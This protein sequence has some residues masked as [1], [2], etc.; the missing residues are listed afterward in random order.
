MKFLYLYLSLLFLVVSS[1]K[2][3]KITV[4][5]P[6][7][8]AVNVVFTDTSKVALYPNFEKYLIEKGIDPEKEPN[9]FVLY[10]FIKEIDSLRFEGPIGSSTSLKGIEGFTN[11]R[12]FKSEGLTVD[13]LNF[14]GNTR[15][16]HFEYLPYPHCMTC[17]SLQVLNF[18]MI[19]SV[20]DF[21]L[22]G[23]NVGS[24][25]LTHFIKLRAFSI[26]NNMGL[27]KLD[28]SASE[29]LEEAYVMEKV[30]V[31]L[32]IHPKLTELT[33]SYT[34]DVSNS[35]ALEKWYLG[36]VG[37]KGVDVSH[38]P[39][40]KSLFIG[41]IT[42]P[43]LDLTSCPKLESL[44]VYGRGNWETIKLDLSKNTM[45]KN[46]KLLGTSLRTICVSSLT[47]IDFTNWEKDSGAAYVK[48]N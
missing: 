4:D 35:P 34:T 14:A 9:G 26:Y 22:Q 6:V 15:L 13:T 11:L 42:S 16:E 39:A 23:S 12:Y 33:S 10:K 3:D 31:K 19:E 30:D 8:E 46:C 2:K 21:Q 45:L 32:G 20:K 7:E 47:D 44:I 48:C 29:L 28:L 38:N 24:L 25:D 5:P 40:L 37:L 41:E 18:G 27:K 1:C 17:A 43:S 36:S